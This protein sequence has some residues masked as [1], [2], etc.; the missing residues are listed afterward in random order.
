VSGGGWALAAVGSR[1]GRGGIKPC[2]VRESTWGK[3]IFR[4][5]TSACSGWGHGHGTGH[6]VGGGGRSPLGAWAP[7]G[8]TGRS[9]TE[10]AHLPGSRLSWGARRGRGGDFVVHRAGLQ[11]PNNRTWTAGLARVGL[12]LRAAVWWAG[13]GRGSSAAFTAA[14]GGGRWVR[15]VLR[16]RRRMRVGGPAAWRWDGSRWLPP[17]RA[18]NPW[19]QASEIVPVFRRGQPVPEMGPRRAGRACGWRSRRTTG[20]ALFNP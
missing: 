5:P 13:A 3:S 11:G 18:A 20:A 6:R 8:S 4:P 14:G 12:P 7:M 15:V 9:G 19:R 10:W 2:R 16:F 1:T 17:A